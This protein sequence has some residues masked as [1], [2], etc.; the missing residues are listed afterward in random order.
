MFIR[1]FFLLQKFLGY[2]QKVVDEFNEFAI[3]FVQNVLQ[4]KYTGVMTPSIGISNPINS[5][6]SL[7]YI[8]RRFIYF[9]LFYVLERIILFVENKKRM[10]RNL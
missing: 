2:F 9:I 5:F 6:Q 8:R 10:E 7:I 4:N 1:K 3:Y